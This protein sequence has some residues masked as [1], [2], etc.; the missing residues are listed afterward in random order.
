MTNINPVALQLWYTGV[1]APVSVLARVISTL[2]PCARRTV[3]NSSLLT[4]SSRSPR[5][6]PRAD[7]VAIERDGDFLRV[8]QTVFMLIRKPQQNINRC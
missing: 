1:F 2:R 6:G 8:G 7:L 4:L 5:L 3:Y